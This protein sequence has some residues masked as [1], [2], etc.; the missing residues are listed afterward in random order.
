MSDEND[1][2]EPSQESLDEIPEA[3]FS[4][5]I[6]PNRYANLRGAFQ[7]AVFLDRDLWAHFGSEQKVI[8]ALR[9]LVDLARREAPSQGPSPPEHDESSSH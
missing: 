8:E 5:A 1:R 9:L 2:N 4:R 6:R 7:H 3:D